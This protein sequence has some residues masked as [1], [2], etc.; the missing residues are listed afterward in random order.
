MQ[1]RNTAL[2]IRY[3]H[4]CR[5]RNVTLST[6]QWVLFHPSGTQVNADCDKNNHSSACLSYLL[7]SSMCHVDYNLSNKEF[8]FASLQYI[9]DICGASL[10]G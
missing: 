6:E 3:V 4:A 8:G 7:H 1:L 9:N 10:T 2:F 5:T